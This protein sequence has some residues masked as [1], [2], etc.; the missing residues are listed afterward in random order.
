MG[1][2]LYH[3][4]ILSSLSGT[5]YVGIASNL[6]NRMWQHKRHAFGGFTA[7]YDVDRLLYY[8]TFGFSEHAIARK[9]NSRDGAGGRRS[10]CHARKSQVVGPKRRLV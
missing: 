5:L 7:K 1:S 9:S 6:R 10:T 4:Y 2:R 8:E 3:V